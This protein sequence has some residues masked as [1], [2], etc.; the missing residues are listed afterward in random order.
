MKKLLI[1]AIIPILIGC[2]FSDGE[3]V[4]RKVI[5]LDSCEYI[6]YWTSNYSS[7]IEHKGNCKFCSQRRKQE[8]IEVL[9]QLKDKEQ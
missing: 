7:N 4:S 5:Y 1:L 9:E 2:V 6:Q 8:M 3:D